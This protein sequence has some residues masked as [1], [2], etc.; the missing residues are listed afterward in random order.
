MIFVQIQASSQVIPL[1]GVPT[2]FLDVKTP[3]EITNSKAPRPPQ[4]FKGFQ[5]FQV[6]IKG[7]DPPSAQVAVPH[8][9]G[10]KECSW[11]SRQEQVLPPEL[12]EAPQITVPLSAADPHHWNIMN[13]P[14]FPNCLATFK[15]R[16]EASLASGAAASTGGAS[17]QGGSSTP[18]RELPLVTWP[19]P[20][21][22]P[23]L[24]W[25]EVDT[26]VTEVKDQV[27]DLHLQL[28]QEMGFVREID[29]ALSKSLMVEF[30]RLKI[31]IED[32]LSRA[33]R[34]WQTDIEVATDKFLRDLDAATQTS[35]TL[36]SKNATVGVALRQ[37]RVAT[38]LRVALPLTRL[39]EAREE[40]ETFI[41][42]RLEELRSPQET[43]NLI[44]ELSSRVTDHRGRVRELLR[45][46]PLRHPEVILLIMVGLAAD[47]PIQSN[48][49]PGLLEGLLGS[50][51]MVA[52]GEVN[53]PTS[54]HDGAGRAWST[55]VCE[56][57][58]RTEQKE[59]EAPEAVGLPPSLDLRY[60]EDFL[61]KQRHLI[62]PVFSDPL[63]IPKMAKAVFRVV[64]PPV[65][66]KALP[67]ARSHEASSAPPQP[68][69]G[70]SEQQVLKLEEPVPSTSQP[71]PQVQEQIS[72]ASN[73]DSDGADEPPSEREPP[74]RSLKVRLPLKLLKRGHQ[75]TASSSKD[76]VTSS[77]VRKETEA[78]T[79]AL[80]GPSEAALSKARFELYQKDLPEVQEV[81]A[82][83][84]DLQEGEVVTQQVL[85]SS[86]TF[87]LRRMADETR[88]P[89]VIGEHWIDH[90]NAGG[91]I[92]K[93]KPHDFKFEDEWLPLYTRA[94]VTRHVSGLSS[95]LKTQGDSPLIA[96]VPPDMLFQSD[97][98]YMIHKLHKEDCL[99]RVTLYYG[100]NLRK[101][102]AFCPYCGVMNEN[103]TTAYSHARKHL[104]ITFLC[105]GCY[106]KLY[107]APQHLSKH[108]K[109]CP[110]CLMNRPEGSRQSV[111]KK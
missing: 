9:Q 93:C 105:G 107:K 87:H 83:I 78:E 44:G 63:F 30:P 80:M 50:L 18:T 99:S 91:H 4:D 53:P 35:T 47:R 33:L 66:S 110:P 96:V 42:S 89:T 100:K 31:I 67:S 62:P 8:L 69:G 52:P 11:I 92:A 94:G 95:L 49:F 51:G 3:E 43:K 7:G 55:A 39:D 32:D 21:P 41:Q 27:H 2:R 40:M 22:T 76:G 77:K 14:I 45:N 46:E 15:V 79:T 29:Q 57:I 72:E 24:E 12:E 36:P 101:Q 58:S 61:E 70:G 111:R 71:T 90:L 10:K 59:V 84:L 16:H 23:P 81:R 103:T 54:S 68:G 60:E 104:G 5:L 1:P 88:P 75:T 74:R 34:T 109:T 6:I 38:Q 56:A 17:S 64:K 97:R 25:Q 37:F 26:R 20:P 28:L 65:V 85:D 13:D 48:F 86:P 19:Q 108:M 82:Q 106:T 98:E 102:I 73:T